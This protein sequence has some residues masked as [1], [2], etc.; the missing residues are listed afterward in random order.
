MYAIGRQ[1][2]TGDLNLDK[3]GVKLSKGGYIIADDY[4]CTSTDY[5]YALG[6]VAEGRP[7]L[8]PTAIQAGTLLAK[9]LFGTASARVS[10]S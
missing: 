6:D 9:R 4:D 10:V 5:I 2:C 7:E 8:T 3:V 1:P